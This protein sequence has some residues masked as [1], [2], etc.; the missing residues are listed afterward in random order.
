MPSFQWEPKYSV[1]V[2]IVDEQHKKIIELLNR[3]SDAIDTEKMKEVLGPI[4][5]EIVAYSN[6]HFITE[7][8]FMTTHHYPDYKSHKKEHDE[9]RAQ[10]LR[11]QESVKEKGSAVG[12]EVVKLL[13]DWLGHHIMF[14]DKRF[15][16]FL[17]SKGVF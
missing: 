16:P 14:V 9:F 12:P 10:A 15:G 5:E 11:L 4:A 17:N 7:E 2:A 1:N 8:F 6:Y 3:L 13:T